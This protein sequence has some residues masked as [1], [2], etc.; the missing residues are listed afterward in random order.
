MKYNPYPSSTTFKYFV[1]QCTYDAFKKGGADMS[2]FVL[3][4]ELP[5]I[6]DHNER[7]SN[8]PHIRMF[9]MW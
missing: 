6:E 4:T 1:N 2:M 8:T 9:D 7:P 3:C 5:K